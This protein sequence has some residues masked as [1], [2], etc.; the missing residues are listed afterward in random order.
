MALPIIA[1]F[2]LICFVMLSNAAP[3]A[4][5]P[6]TNT[7]GD[8]SS[9][10]LFQAASALKIPCED[11][12]SQRICIGIQQSGKCNTEGHI[13]YCYKTCTKCTGIVPKA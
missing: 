3:Q 13:K 8:L 10:P 11:Y 6:E 4:A 9:F 7:Q 1:S 12:H 2:S 5:V